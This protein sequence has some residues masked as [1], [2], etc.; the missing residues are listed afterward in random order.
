MTGLT[1]AED[2]GRRTITGRRPIVEA[3]VAAATLE[4]P[5]VTVRRGVCVA[6]LLPGPSEL[7]GMPRTTGVVT[8]TGEQVTAD[9]VID[10]TGQARPVAG[11]AEPGARRA[12][13]VSRDIDDLPPGGHE[14]WFWHIFVM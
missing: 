6:G 10:A 1:G 13:T 7:P 14:T 8:G 3:V 2:A 4:R 9:L 11:L 5:G 12:G